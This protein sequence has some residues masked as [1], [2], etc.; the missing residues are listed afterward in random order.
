[1]TSKLAWI[2]GKWFR[3]GFAKRDRGGKDNCLEGRGNLNECA[4]RKGVG[5]KIVHAQKR[6]AA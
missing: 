6:V 5:I 3:N 4:V 1:M 2:R